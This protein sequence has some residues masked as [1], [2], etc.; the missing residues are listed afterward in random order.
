[1]DEF[2][3]GNRG[4]GPR[5][6][7]AFRCY[8]SS[9]EDGGWSEQA[10]VE[11]TSDAY[12]L[13]AQ[14]RR[15]APWWQELIHVHQSLPEDASSIK[16]KWFC[17]K[18]GVVFFYAVSRK[19]RR[20]QMYALSLETLAVENLACRDGGYNPW[21]AAELYRGRTSPLGSTSRPRFREEVPGVGVRLSLVHAA[22]VQAAMPV[23][24]AASGHREGVCAGVFKLEAYHKPL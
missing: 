2:P 7:T 13:E 11:E 14:Q 19:C 24:L 3:T 20:Y 15:R 4:T 22:P 10:W 23:H 5:F 9:E 18:S 8:D 1:M 12:G 21:P 6:S 16:L 17:D